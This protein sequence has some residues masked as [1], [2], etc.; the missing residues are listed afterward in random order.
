MP[1]DFL[2]DVGRGI[3]DA[4]QDFGR[5]EKGN[6]FGWNAGFVGVE[7]PGAGMGEAEAPGVQHETS[8]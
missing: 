6:E 2:Q 8:R 4:L 3:A 7:L 1:K 5:G